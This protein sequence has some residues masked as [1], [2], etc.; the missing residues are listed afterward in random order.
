M[1]KKDVNGAKPERL[2]YTQ[3]SRRGYQ[4]PGKTINPDY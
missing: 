1:I 2:S 4:L 3:S